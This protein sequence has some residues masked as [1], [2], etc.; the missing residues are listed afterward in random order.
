MFPCRRSTSRSGRDSSAFS[1][2]ELLVVVAIIALLIAMLFPV[3]RHAH[4]KVKRT[5]CLSNLRQIYMGSANYANQNKGWFPNGYLTG[6]WPFRRAPGELD[7][8][9][10]ELGPETYGLAAVL[11]R[12][13]DFPGRSEAWI[14]PAATRQMQS[15]RNTYQF[16]YTGVVEDRKIY[17]LPYSARNVWVFDNYNVLPGKPGRPGQPFTN[18]IDCVLPPEVVTYP[19]LI[20]NV[21]NVNLLPGIWAGVNSLFFD[22]HVALVAAR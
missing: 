13:H 10:P 22:G 21:V 20:N 1:L 18:T 11:D 17:K 7:P 15:Y 4:H 6:G 9:E 12:T 14:C 16:V 5:V 2:I 8:E 3:L 19:H